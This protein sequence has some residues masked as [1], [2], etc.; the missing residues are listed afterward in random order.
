MKKQSS[1][2]GLYAVAVLAI[3]VFA[4]V[5]VYGFTINRS[6]SPTTSTIQQSSTLTISATGTVY[7]SSSQSVIYV[8]M[9]GTGKTNQQAVQ[10]ISATL[11]K[12]NSTIMKYV[13][14]NASLITTSYFN[15]YK[16]YNKSSYEAS[17]S[18]S[19]TIPDI[20]NT[21]AAIGALSN[22]TN[23]YVGGASPELS[24]AQV[25][26]MR[27]AALSLALSNAT[28]QA[29]A[30]LRNSTIYT[31][32]ITINNYYVYPIPYRLD[33]AISGGSGVTTTI[34]PEFYGGTNKVTESITV[35]F[36][37]GTKRG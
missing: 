30:L 2:L 16:V 36:V 26:A 28:A 9:N 1:M 22:I 35:V 15:V 13:N 10:N 33:L 8:T 21:S 3:L 18:L 27:V 24:D 12:F 34:P 7:N 29:H 23:V 31:T 37:Y 17:E 14:N 11:Q 32:N 19:V 4:A 6:Q 20:G 25:S 5:M